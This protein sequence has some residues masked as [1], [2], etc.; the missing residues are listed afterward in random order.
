MLV[1]SFDIHHVVLFLHELHR[2]LELGKQGWNLVLLFW[3]GRLLLLSE[4][5]DVSCILLSW[6]H[7]LFWSKLASSLRNYL[8]HL[9]RILIWVSGCTRFILLFLA[10]LQK[11]RCKHLVF[12]LYRGFVEV[13]L[14]IVLGELVESVFIVCFVGEDHLV[15]LLDE[16]T[17]EW[18]RRFL[19]KG[20]VSCSF[21]HV[22]LSTNLL[23]DELKL[24]LDVL[25]SRHV[26][27]SLNTLTICHLLALFCFFSFFLLNTGVLTSIVVFNTHRFII[28]RQGVVSQ[29]LEL[30]FELAFVNKVRIRKIIVNAHLLLKFKLL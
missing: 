28:F 25:I 18:I 13:W 3:L 6:S 14:A 7:L 16:I 20:N 15:A 4:L 30:L 24:L 5:L 17:F 22:L 9:F 1:G 8:P 23:L 21:E 19:L 10:L 11:V 29:L 2:C 26:L 27:S 12:S